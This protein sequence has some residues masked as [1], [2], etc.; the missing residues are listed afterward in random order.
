M[1]ICSTIVLLAQ[2]DDWTL[3][4]HVGA[5]L[6]PCFLLLS[7]AKCVTISFRRTTSSICVNSL[8]LLLLSMALLSLLRQAEQLGFDVAP[9]QPFATPSRSKRT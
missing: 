9:I 7:A 1:G 4:N 6:V 2:A 8:A 5:A 3:A